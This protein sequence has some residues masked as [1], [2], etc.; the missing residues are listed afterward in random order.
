MTRRRGSMSAEVAVLVPAL[1]LLVTLAVGRGRVFDVG[2]TVRAA[3]DVAAR[4]ASLS[5]LDRMQ[6]NGRRA[7]SSFVRDAG[8]RCRDLTIEVRRE[9]SKGFLYATA[10]VSCSVD[11]RDLGGLMP[12]AMR[13]SATS[14]EI[15]D[16]FRSDQ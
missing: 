15:I 2:I 14:R 6:I 12:R 5:S 4:T 3:A 9:E 8:V 1:F 7:G 11:H 10:M 16:Y 13:L